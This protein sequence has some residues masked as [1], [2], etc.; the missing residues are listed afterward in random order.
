MIT[1]TEKA[2][3]RIKRILD[4]KNSLNRKKCLPEYLGFRLA[5]K[6][7]GCSGFEYYFYPFYYPDKYDAIFES[8]GVKIYVDRK[9]LVVVKGT[10]I[11][12][13]G[14]LLEGFIFNNP[15]AKNGCGCGTS[16]ELK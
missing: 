6:A 10:E 14:N 5:V 8:Y 9:S 3:L 12:H 16:F 11:D 4:E 15:N 2:A 13:T 7:G 1:V